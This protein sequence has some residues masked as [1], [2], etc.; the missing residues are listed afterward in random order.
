M[1]KPLLEKSI[2][3]MLTA[4]LLLQNNHYPSTVNRAYYSCLQF[5][6]HILIEKLGH[7]HEY[8]DSMPGSGTH[9][10]AQYLL[11]LTLIKKDKDDYKWFQAKFPA[12][13]KGRVIA[14]YH[15]APLDQGIGH[16]A[17]NTANL[18]IDTLKKYYK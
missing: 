3:S 14:D 18:I 2:Q 4:K 16:D 7:T 11:S 8:I 9:G 5:I 13:K 6:L 10:K 1:T 12:F 15:S 17:I